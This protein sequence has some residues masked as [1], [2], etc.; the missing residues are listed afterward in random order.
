M[1]AP[2]TAITTSTPD[3]EFHIIIDGQGI[4]KT[5][6][7]GP[8]EELAKRLPKELHLA[9]ILSV[10]A[11]PYQ[12]LVEDYYNGN[13]TALDKI[14]RQQSGSDFQQKVWQA[15][16]SIGYGQTMSY[17]QL[18]AAAGNQK[19]IRS[20]GTICGLNRLILLVP[21]HRILKSDGS[22]GNYLYGPTIKKSLL[23][24]EKG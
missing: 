11:H 21:C 12:K 6:G 4:A 22:I 15:I 17:K 10:G 24:R 5:S 14:P 9:K 20:A 18:A 19:A 8:L 13:K 2:L 7:F 16:S 1:N 23:N 3:G